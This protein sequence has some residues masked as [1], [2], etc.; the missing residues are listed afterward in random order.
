[1]KK[2]ALV[3]ALFFAIIAIIFAAHGASA[4]TYFE[5]STNEAKMCPCSTVQ[6][7]GSIKSD[8]SETY[9]L[10]ANSDWAT[11][12]PDKITLNA[13]ESS[14]IYTYLT[15]DCSAA[16][17]KYDIE[18]TAK[19]EAGTKKQQTVSAT[20]LPCHVI[21]VEPDSDK[22]SACIEDSVKFN[23]TVRNGGKNNESLKLSATKG[24]LSE[25]SIDIERG[26]SKNVI[27]TVPIDAQE[28][29]INVTAQSDSSYAG[30]KIALSAYG[31]S[32]RSASMEIEPLSAETCS[33][34]GSAKYSVKITNS[35]SKNETFSLTSSFGALSENTV[36]LPANAKKEILLLV[37][38]KEAKNYNITV[39][40]V[41]SNIAL[42]KT[43]ALNS[44]QC[45][46][47][48][49]AI[50][51]AEKSACINQNA[52]YSVRV[53]NT[54]KL[55][56]TYVLTASMG[57][58]EKKALEIPAGQSQSVLLTI[59][60]ENMGKGDYPFNVIAE[61]SASRQINSIASAKFSAEDCVLSS[62]ASEPENIPL[63]PGKEA[64]F[65]ILVENTGKAPLNYTLKSDYG[66][67]DE[68]ALSVGVSGKKSATLAV[69][70]SPQDSGK[71]NITVYAQANGK[72]F[73][74]TVGLEF[75]S[76]EKCYGF[77][78][79]PVESTLYA[80][81]TKGKLFTIVI[82]NE[83]SE[84]A[85]FNASIDGPSWAYIDPKAIEIAGGKAKETYIYA[86]A[87]YGT[88]DDDYI[89]RADVKSSSGRVKSTYVQLVVGN[90]TPAD[91]SRLRA[92]AD[93]GGSGPAMPTAQAAKTWTTKTI[94]I[95]IGGI[96][97]IALVI[98]GPEIFGRK[99]KER[100]GE[101]SAS[102]EPKEEIPE[103][104]AHQN[105]TAS[106]E[107]A[108][109]AESTE[110]KK[111]QAPSESSAGQRQS[112][113]PKAQE[114]QESPID[115]ENEAAKAQLSEIESVIEELKKEKPE[116]P[117]KKARKKKSE[118]GDLSDISD[119]VAG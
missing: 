32:C 26:Q 113:E 109:S 62:I 38:P 71:K 45:R 115:A 58:L 82:K 116:K 22:K 37:S 52:T 80:N 19:T 90:A 107:S 44:V 75:I 47:V 15:S 29:K 101:T 4:A 9:S 91:L 49:A 112:Q 13:G 54:G 48:S 17:G 89:I 20:I 79:A 12:A 96:I 33:A 56:D 35:G 31:Y 106:G 114:P 30:G 118:K 69:G 74:K 43:A 86:A 42:E 70:T 1:M 105:E 34:E 95:L 103:Y 68:A 94:A 7:V 92:D 81:D 72:T 23:I 102:G 10:K 41:S 59:S 66:A 67:F 50:I 11:I 51:P 53:S 25:N 28:S 78:I 108:E 98:F 5:L 100:V 76:P 73:S 83:G 84:S 36:S 117:A 88:R 63:C 57:A 40:A 99:K 16:P 21:S 64:R 104:P 2:T 77:A 110:T 87:P 65:K 93:S 39:K 24:A 85:V 119:A 61:S 55:N 97:L 8:V 46:S 6:I 27:L 3:S 14:A 111:T 60:A 18:I